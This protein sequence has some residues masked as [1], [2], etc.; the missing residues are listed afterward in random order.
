[1]PLPSNCLAGRCG[2]GT[3]G[4]GIGL[5][6]GGAAVGAGAIALPGDLAGSP[7]R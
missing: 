1:M 2:A 4:G 5:L 6:A 3:T 7:T